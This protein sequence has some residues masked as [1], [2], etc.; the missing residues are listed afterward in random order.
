MKQFGDDGFNR[1]F[2]IPYHRF[3]TEILFY[4]AETLR[5]AAQAVPGPL[6]ATCTHSLQRTALLLRDDGTLPMVGDNDESFVHKFDLR[7]SNQFGHFPALAWLLDGAVPSRE[8]PVSGGPEVFWLRGAEA[9]Q[10]FVSAPVVRRP[11]S[12]VRL[13]ADGSR[14]TDDGSRP[15][16]SSIASAPAFGLHTADSSSWRFE[17]VCRC[18]ASG[19][20]HSDLLSL[21]ASYRDTDV[22]I[23]PGNAVYTSDLPRRNAARG[24]ANHSALRVNGIDYSMFPKSGP[25]G[26]RAFGRL[27]AHPCQAKLDMTRNGPLFTGQHLAYRKL[28]IRV[29]RKVWV[30]ATSDELHIEDSA[31]P[32]R[33]PSSV[34]RD[35][36]AGRRTTDDGRRTVRVEWSFNIGT[37]RILEQNDQCVDFAVN[38]RRLSLTCTS[39]GKFS[40]RET[41][42]SPAFGIALPGTIIGYAMNGALPLHA[43]FVV[44]LHD[45]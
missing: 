26:R 42:T 38:D 17:V 43:H 29:L 40:S 31:E 36:P 7:P 45:D 37:N 1:E 22:F 35:P 6:A 12:I 24:V 11:S 14:I 19:H 34:T 32:T 9:H 15:T 4:A 44:S 20:A 33:D 41:E 3:A 2:S 18:G 16:T 30:D 27:K 5:G 39:S 8:F 21:T 28:G 25:R 13:P 23:D 10:Q